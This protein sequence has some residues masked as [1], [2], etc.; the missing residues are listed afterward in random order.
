MKNLLLLAALLLFAAPSVFADGFAGFPKPFTATQSKS[1]G[2]TFT[3]SFQGTKVRAVGKGRAAALGTMISDVKDGTATM[4]LDDSKE[5]YSYKGEVDRSFFDPCAAQKQALAQGA[6][7]MTCKKEGSAV[8]NGRKT[9]KYVTSMPGADQTLESFFDP[10]LKV[11]VKQRTPDGGTQELKD[12][13]VG[14]VSGS[15]DAPKGY[16]KISQEQ[17]NAKVLKRSQHAKH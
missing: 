11:V 4:V 14:A 13:K 15:F 6:A 17:Y 8:V 12:I 9:D 16:A 3:M 7:G 10:E 1:D 5:Y 2:S